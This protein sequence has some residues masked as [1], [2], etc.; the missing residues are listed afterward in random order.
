MDKT[1]EVT[2]G[3]VHWCN[4]DAKKTKPKKTIIAA[5]NKENAMYLNS[6]YYLGNLCLSGHKAVLPSGDRINKS[7]RRLD[8]G[9]CYMCLILYAREHNNKT[10]SD[11]TNETRKRIE[12]IKLAKELGV[13]IDD[14]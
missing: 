3:S 7:I 6:K 12:D 1:I 10:G 13:S 8:S 9:A 11:T 5:T 14:L 4:F 2:T